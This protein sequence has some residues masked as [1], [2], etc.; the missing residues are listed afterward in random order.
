MTGVRRARRAG[1]LAAALLLG[2]A[3]L[4]PLPALA[5]DL[6][7]TQVLPGA[8]LTAITIDLN[9]DGTREVLRLVDRELPGMDL[10]A[11][12]VRQDTWLQV[13]STEV[14]SHPGPDGSLDPSSEI[15]AILRM[16]IDGRDHAVL[17]TASMLLVPNVP[18]TVCCVEL[19]DVVLVDDRLMLLPLQT[20]DLRAEFLAA[21]DMDGDGTDELVTQVTTY[22]DMNDSGTYRVEVHAWTGGGFRR[23]FTD[24]RDGQGFGVMP[25]EA[26]GQPGAELYVIPSAAGSVERLVMVDG[27]INLERTSAD[28]GQPFEAWFLG[29][30]N[31]RVLLQEPEGVRLFEWPRDERPGELGRINSLAYPRVDVV[32]T[33]EDA[34]FVVYEGFDYLGSNQPRMTLL[35]MDFNE[36][37]SIPISERIEPLWDAASRISSRGYGSSRSLFPFVGLLPEPGPRE[38]WPYLANGIRIEAGG[39]G[40]YTLADANPLIGVVP[41]GRAGPDDAWL[42]LGQSMFSGYY[43]PF[44]LSDSAV[45]LFPFAQGPFPETPS[46]A[47]L[48]LAPADAI[49]APSDEAVATVRADGAVAVEVDGEKRL[50]ASYDGFDVVIDAPLGSF[51]TYEDRGG[52]VELSVGDGPLVVE[53]RAPNGP[54]NRNRDFTRTFFIVAPDGRAQVVTFEGTFIGEGPEVTA[55]A[56]TDAFAL[57]SRIFGRA[58]DG[59]QVTVDG[60]P[61]ELNGNGAYSVEVG[62]PIWPR[63]VVVI[64]RDVLGNESVQR[65]QIVGFLDYRGLPW[66][67]IIGLATVAAGAFL[68]VRTPRRRQ[69]ERVGWGDA[70]LEEIDGDSV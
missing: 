61:A 22:A 55:N 40:G 11:W 52:P 44:G 3:N 23:I 50:A 15:A 1:G 38:S 24:D 45:Y 13:A 43:G 6:P 9:Q 33:G 27:A 47:T 62:A 17:A 39:A 70:R 51:V 19:A 7:A 37:A 34:L 67:V 69:T 48:T 68:F 56:D 60:V 18:S 53:F 46:A 49:L 20:Q 66:A 14:A 65:L 29:A 10:E 28:L 57:S 12:S 2:V 36:I 42:A 16:R 21:V 25:G 31:G 58:S 63:D 35:D 54:T 64:A 5:A 59:V 32:G 8:T 41:I 26:D 30:A 4:V